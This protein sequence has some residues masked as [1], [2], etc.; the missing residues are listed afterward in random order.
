[1]AKLWKGN[2]NMIGL[3]GCLIAVVEL[4]AGTNDIK[5]EGSG[6]GNWG[7]QSDELSRVTDE[8]NE[9]EKNLNVEKPAGEEDAAEGSTETPA[10]EVEEKE[11]ED[12]AAKVTV[13]EY[14]FDYKKL[15]NVQS[16]LL[17]GATTLVRN[18]SITSCV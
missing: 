2:R 8:V 5:R 15:A 11:P 17:G 7:T 3:E 14:E 4:G 12:K 18:L 9:G 1:M 13:K 16:H 10:K 6:R